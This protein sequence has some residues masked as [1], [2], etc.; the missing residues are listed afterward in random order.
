MRNDGLVVNLTLFSDKKKRGAMS[1]P[2]LFPEEKIPFL[3][4][5]ISDQANRAE[6][7]ETAPTFFMPPIRKSRDTPK[8]PNQLP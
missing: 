3:N 8:I 4:P 5:R 7:T 1:V 2:F 6:L